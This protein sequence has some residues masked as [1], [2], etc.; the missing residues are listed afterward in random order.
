MSWGLWKSSG[1]VVN[2]VHGVF[3]CSIRFAL[4]YQPQLCGTELFALIT[5]T[6]LAHPSARSNE[7]R[8]SYRAKRLSRDII[9]RKVDEILSTARDCSGNRDGT[10][11]ELPGDQLAGLHGEVSE[12]AAGVNPPD[13]SKLPR[14]RDKKSG[15][16]AGGLGYDHIHGTSFQD[17]GD[18][19]WHFHSLL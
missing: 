9:F 10:W 14:V 4:K 13:R 18:Q 2:P 12:H 3:I 19:E 17:D 11:K 16:G 8:C 7:T 1:V 6:L 5:G 15:C